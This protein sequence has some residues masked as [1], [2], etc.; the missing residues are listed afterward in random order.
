MNGRAFK[1]LQQLQLELADYV[2]WFNHYRIHKK[3][4]YITPISFKENTLKKLSS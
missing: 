3:L 1:H 4:N 2:H